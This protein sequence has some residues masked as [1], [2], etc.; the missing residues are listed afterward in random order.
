MIKEGDAGVCDFCVVT[1]WGGMSGLR[2]CPGE[3]V[4]QAE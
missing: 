3:K 1:V 2:L 4:V